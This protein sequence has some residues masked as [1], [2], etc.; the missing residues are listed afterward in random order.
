[1]QVEKHDYIKRKSIPSG[2]VQFV[3]YVCQYREGQGRQL[4]VPT[5]LRQCLETRVA[6]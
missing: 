2:F 3:Q 6:I 1:M 5:T 4:H